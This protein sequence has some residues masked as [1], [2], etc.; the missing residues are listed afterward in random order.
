MQIKDIKIQLDRANKLLAEKE[1]EIASVVQ[2]ENKAVQQLK[3]KLE[4][5]ENEKKLLEVI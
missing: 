3:D 5:M 4:I 2:T 1:G